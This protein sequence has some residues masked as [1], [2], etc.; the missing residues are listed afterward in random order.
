MTV[1]ADLPENAQ[2]ALRLFEVVVLNLSHELAA[3]QE[4]LDIVRRELGD[5]E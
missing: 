2:K 1:E 3:A 5:R 4:R